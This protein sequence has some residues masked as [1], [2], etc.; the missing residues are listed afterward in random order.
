MNERIH[1]PSKKRRS[2]HGGSDLDR[3][4]RGFTKNCEISVGY[5]Y[6]CEFS[7][8]IL[9][10]ERSGIVLAQFSGHYKGA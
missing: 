10:D 7:W 8:W 1:P 2:T 3:E 5:A 6:P 4:S 9:Y